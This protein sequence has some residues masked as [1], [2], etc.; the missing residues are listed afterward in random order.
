V[1]TIATTL[2]VLVGGQPV[3]RYKEGTEL[4]DVWLR[5]DKPFR[6]NPDSLSTL[7]IPSPMTGLVQLASVARLTEARGPSQI[8]RFNRQRTVTLLGNPDG[9]SLNDAVQ[10]ARAAVRELDLPPQ[11]EVSYGGQAKLLGDTGYYFMIAFVLSVLFM[12]LILAA[13]FESWVAPVS[14]LA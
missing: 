1:Q 9:L 7:T 12:Y 3:S 6:A 10:Q 13:Q 2:N 4:Y 8:D 11:Y 5:A 14:I